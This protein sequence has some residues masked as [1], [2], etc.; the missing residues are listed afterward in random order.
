LLDHLVG[1]L[2]A[3]LYVL[4]VNRLI[5]CLLAGLIGRSVA[6]SCRPSVGWWL[7]GRFVSQLF[8]RLLGLVV[9]FDLLVVC[10]LVRWLVCLLDCVVASLLSLLDG[11]R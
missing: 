9:C 7:V 5:F 3:R 1:W 2:V 6:R 4:S 10:W 11:G 8:G